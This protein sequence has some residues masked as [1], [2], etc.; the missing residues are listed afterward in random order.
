LNAE[1]SA[2]AE[3]PGVN[4][5]DAL[6]QLSLGCPSALGVWVPDWV[7]PDVVWE[8]PEPAAIAGPAMQAARA[9]AATVFN[10]CVMGCSCHLSAIV[11][12][13]HLLAAWKRITTGYA[14]AIRA[15]AI[16]VKLTQCWRCDAGMV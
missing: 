4:G 10:K 14:P 2:E 12:T 1:P 7:L 11:P 3:S 6:P 13:I 15:C 9:L 16:Q 8:P 5:A